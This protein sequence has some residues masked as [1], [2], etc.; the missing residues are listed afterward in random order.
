MKGGAACQR[1]PWR[2][3]Y[4]Q[5]IAV[6]SSASPVRPYSPAIPVS[7]NTASTKRS[8]SRSQWPPI[9]LRCGCEIRRGGAGRKS[10]AGDH[11]FGQRPGAPDVT[12]GAAVR[13]NPVSLQHSKPQR[14]LRAVL[15]PGRRLRIRLPRAGIQPVA[16]GEFQHVLACHACFSQTP[17]LCLGRPWPQDRPA[18][19][20]A[21][22]RPP[23]PRSA[24]ACRPAS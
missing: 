5:W 12:I 23:P 16:I 19:D 9:S 14:H 7:S 13:H 11:H 15:Q 1:S 2:G 3:E 10:G 6:P 18:P 24:A 22:H 8:L 20:R 17:P 4:Q 21:K